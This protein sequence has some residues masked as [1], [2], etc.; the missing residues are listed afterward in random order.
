MKIENGYLVFDKEQI[1]LKK[2]TGHRF[3]QL[4]GKSRF[5]TKGDCLVKMFLG[6]KEDPI[7][8][9]YIKRGAIGE[10]LVE[11]ELMRMGVKVNHYD[12]KEEN[13]DMFKEDPN[14][15]G[16]IDLATDNFETIY[17]C[18]SKPLSKY[19][20]YQD[21]ANEEEELQCELY[22]YLKGSTNAVMKYIFFDTESESAIKNSKPFNLS[23]ITI[24][25]K[26]LTFDRMELC[27]LMDYALNYRDTCYEE[28]R[29]P[30]ADISADMLLLLQRDYGLDIGGRR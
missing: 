8:P 15:G 26:L 27:E 6:I 14:Y 13:Y 4:L 1:K 30:Q 16:V 22:A 18:K 29:I 3:P 20:W 12:T 10:F 5:T 24:Y 19:E 7:D 23:G 25:D 28:K 21:N 11:Y 9:F 2:I 17:E